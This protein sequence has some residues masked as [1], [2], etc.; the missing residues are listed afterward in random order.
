MRFKIPVMR[1]LAWLV[2]LIAA[3]ATWQSAA[4]AATALQDDGA[5]QSGEALDDASCLHCHD[6]KLPLTVAD[7]DGEERPLLAIDHNKYLKGLHGDMACIDCHKEIVDSKAQHEKSTAP[8]PSCIS[9]HEDLWETAREQDLTREKARLGVVVQNIEAYKESFHARPAP[10]NK[11][12]VKAHCEDCHDTHYF[13]VPPRGTTKRTEWHVT[14]PSVCGEACHEDSLEEYLVS[15]HGME[16]TEKN[17]LKTAVCTDCHTTH[18]I[19]KTTR[20]P[21]QL[22]VTKQ[23]G[24]CHEDQFA[25]YRDTYHG[26]I[27]TL[28]YADTAKCFD[29]HG[30]HEI[31]R[32]DDPESMVHPDNRLETCQ[33]CH[34]GK[35]IIKATE[36]FMS[37][38]PHANSHDY[39]RYPQVW[40]AAKFMHGLLLLVFSYFWAHSLLWWYREYRDRKARKGQPRIR[41]DEVPGIENKQVRRFGLIWRIGHLFFALS[42]MMLILT[43]MAVYYAYTAWAPVV[44]N[45]L[46]GPEIAGL[47]HRISAA[48]MLGIF[49]LHLIGVSINIARKGK[50]FRWFGPDSLV[51]NWKDLKDAWGMF[52]WF[53]GKGPRPVFDRWTYWEKFD[54]WA[55]FWGMAIIGGSGMLLSFPDITAAI[56]PGW[57]FNVVMLIHG[58]EA[59]LAA[60]FLFTVHF[61]NN[62]FR[63]DKLPPPD[64][65][66]FT[67]TQSLKEFRRDHSMQYDRLVETGE[68]DN[69]LV[70]APSRP[71]TVGS[72]IL[73]LTL[74]AIGLV[75]LFI[76]AAGF[77]EG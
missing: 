72:K 25:T 23:C 30:S 71:M 35:D 38:G 3:Q 68:L 34:D 57:V 61:F 4:V 12:G 6:G 75:L 43:G 50:N 46:G 32:I 2:W 65:V 21:F 63:P 58:E 49:F 52:V 22:L 13:N 19:S 31:L 45:V 7:K 24:S 37:F 29:C 66:M 39:E 62:H 14:I 40:I 17:N 18:D 8:K 26:Q 5:V 47:I 10:S 70:D 51:P 56:F 44:I 64:V 28:G 55:V 53:V 36:G 77:L 42:V 16:T 48:I 9:C 1:L 33:E 74:I 69:Y 41:T 11:S 60:V 73:G 54:Y 67:G 76:V 20:D 15:V 59:F 27:N